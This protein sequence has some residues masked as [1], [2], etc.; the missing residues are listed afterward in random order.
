[1]ADE[2][3]LLCTAIARMSELHPTYRSLVGLAHRDL[4]NMIRARRAKL[5]G[6]SPDTLHDP[7]EAISEISSR[8]RLDLIHNAVYERRPGARPWG[9]DEVLF[10]YVE[11]EWTSAARYL[12]THAAP[13]LPAVAANSAREEFGVMREPEGTEQSATEAVVSTSGKRGRGPLP[14][15]LEAT[16]EAMRARIRDGS[17]SIDGLDKMLEKNMANTFRVSRDTCRKARQAVLSDREFVEKHSRQTS[18]NSNK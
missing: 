17:L 11:I 7:P 3:L 14:T 12:R 9:G 18:T 8:H 10:R 6:R 15:K 16:T 13:A 2:W 4:E 5:R 1:M